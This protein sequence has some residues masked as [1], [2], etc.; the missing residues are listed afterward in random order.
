MALIWFGGIVIWFFG[1]YSFIWLDSNFAMPPPMPVDLFGWLTWSAIF[2]GPPIVVFLLV[3][4]INS[5]LR[6][7][8]K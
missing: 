8:K 7:A 6:I 4:G 2:V 5:I 1:L 3:Y